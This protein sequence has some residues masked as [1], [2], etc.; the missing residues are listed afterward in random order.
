MPEPAG[1]YERTKGLYSSGTA[2][3][4][5]QFQKNTGPF[6][7]YLFSVEVV[8]LSVVLVVPSFLC[9]L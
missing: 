1:Y 9:F 3:F 4:G 2:K 6:R 7:D 8:V 5:E